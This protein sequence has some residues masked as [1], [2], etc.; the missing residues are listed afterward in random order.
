MPPH[1]VLFFFSSFS[2]LFF[3][4]LFF[5]VGWL[6]GWFYLCFLLV[7]GDEVQVTMLAWQAFYL[8]TAVPPGPIPSP[9]RSNVPS[10]KPDRLI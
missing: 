9:V 8:L 3:S 5:L 10:I 6:L 2:F 4:F 7:S 1:L